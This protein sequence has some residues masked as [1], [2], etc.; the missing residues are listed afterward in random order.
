MDEP[1]MGDKAICSMCGAEI[2]YV[3]PYWRHTG[4]IQP[5]HPATPKQ[6]EQPP[7]W[8]G[9][10]DERM[11]KH[12]AYARHYADN[13]AHGAPGHL[14]LMTIAALAKKLDALWERQGPNVQP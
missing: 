3:G 9:D 1:K 14:D 10:L 5:R 13:Y 2:E 8:M 6:Q 7:Q 12:I 11:N 4:A